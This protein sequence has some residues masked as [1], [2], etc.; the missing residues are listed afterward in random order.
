MNAVKSKITHDVSGWSQNW[1]HRLALDLMSVNSDNN[2][3]NTKL[4]LEGTKNSLCVTSECLQKWEKWTKSACCY[5][6]RVHVCSASA[7]SELRES[8]QCGGSSSGWHWWALLDRLSARMEAGFTL[9]AWSRVTIYPLVCVPTGLLIDAAAAQWFKWKRFP[10]GI[11]W[12]AT[13]VTSVLSSSLF[14]GDSW[15]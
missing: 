2:N 14:H 10:T 11:N 1:S 5:L 8:F 4:T 7:A 12:L 6:H 9:P 13:T 3:L 15:N